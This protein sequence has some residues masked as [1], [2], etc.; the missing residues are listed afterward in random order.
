MIAYKYEISRQCYE[1]IYAFYYHVA[2]KYRHTYSEELM[3]KNIDDAIDSMY[4]IERTLLRRQPSVKRWL[5]LNMA[6]TDTWYF[7]YTIENDTIII[8]DACHAQNMHDEE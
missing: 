3:H 8:V 4:Q 1:E 6:N 5:G 2:L 7:A